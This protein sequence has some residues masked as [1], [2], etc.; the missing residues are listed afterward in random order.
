MEFYRSKPNLTKKE[1]SKWYRDEYV[2][3]ANY[4]VQTVG[5]W[6]LIK[7]T[8]PY[9]H[10]PYPYNPK[11]D[12]SMST[13]VLRNNKVVFSI[14]NSSELLSERMGCSWVAFNFNTDK[15]V[16][17]AGKYTLKTFI[18]K[19]Y[20]QEVFRGATNL[21]AT[22]LWNRYKIPLSVLN[23]FGFVTIPMASPNYLY[24]KS[25]FSKDVHDLWHENLRDARKAGLKYN[26]KDRW[27]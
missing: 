5:E 19:A 17:V 24:Q 21:T 23:K 13:F 15:W 25:A 12:N 3:I 22:D 10:K 16:D 20:N 9:A 14:V 1:L 4:P 7:V 26:N 18:K 8:S 11:Y 27:E 2:K 6:S